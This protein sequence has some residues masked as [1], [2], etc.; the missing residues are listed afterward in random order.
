MTHTMWIMTLSCDATLQRIKQ[1]YSSKG[2]RHS[3][4]QVILLL[5]LLILYDTEGKESLQGPERDLSL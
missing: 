3:L 4:S 2:R 1:S 5:L